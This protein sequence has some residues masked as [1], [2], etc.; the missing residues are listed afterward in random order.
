M[1]LYLFV[2]GINR[3]G[4]IAEH[5]FRDV[6]LQIPTNSFVLTLPSE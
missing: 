3:Y 5:A 4:R 6:W 2:V 1:S